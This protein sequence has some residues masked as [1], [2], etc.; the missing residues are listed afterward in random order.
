M[1]SQELNK[2]ILEF[3]EI[4]AVSLTHETRKSIARMLTKA[5]IDQAVVDPLREDIVTILTEI[6]ESIEAVA[7]EIVY[8][9]IS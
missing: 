2:L 8:Q 1:T 4:T 7:E 3:L 6:S 9:E 5:C